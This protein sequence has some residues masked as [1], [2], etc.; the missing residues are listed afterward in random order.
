MLNRS[1]LIL[2]DTI[3][4]SPSGSSVHGD[5]P[6]KNTRMGCHFLLQGIFPIQG[7]NPGL[8]HCRWILYCVSHQGSPRTLE[9]VAYPF[10][11][12]SF[13]PRNQTGVSIV[14]GLF[15]S[16]ATRE[17]HTE[18]TWCQILVTMP[19]GLGLSWPLLDHSLADFRWMRSRLICITLRLALIGGEF[20]Q[21]WLKS[22]RLSM[23]QGL[24]AFGKCSSLG[25][26]QTHVILTL[27]IPGVLTRHMFFLSSLSDSN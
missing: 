13:Q 8:P 20:K 17:A 7:W 12:R 6:D 2:C 21:H 3:D 22:C 14:G 16:W 9:W 25:S 15:T 10:S 19:D 26:M 27:R 18:N 24:Q 4:C 23:F 5:S 1:V 11:R